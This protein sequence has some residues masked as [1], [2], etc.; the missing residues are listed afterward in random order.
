MTVK[1]TTFDAWWAERYAGNRSGPPLECERAAY[2]A[3]LTH[4]VA[5]A[6]EYGDRAERAGARH[7]DNSA[8]RQ[9][10]VQEA[11]AAMQ[12]AKRIGNVSAYPA[13]DS[14]HPLNGAA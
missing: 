8:I 5:I 12:I 9:L 1:L 6:S 4:A 3:G 14:P 13:S 2:D 10:L 7:P 11:Y